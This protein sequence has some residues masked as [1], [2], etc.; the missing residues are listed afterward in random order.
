MNC[1]EVRENAAAALMTGEQNQSSVADHLDTCDNCRREIDELL[2]VVDLLALAPPPA[3]TRQPDDLLLH[4][5]LVQVA[6]ERRRRRMVIGIAVAASVALILAVPAALSVFSDGTRPPATADVATLSAQAADAQT[7]VR[8]TAQLQSSAV[9]SDLVVS[10]RGVEAG[11]RCRLL[12]VNRDGERSVV[13]TWTASY[14]GRATVTTTTTLSMSQVSH[15]E[16]VDAVDAGLL[17]RLD[18]S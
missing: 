10:V 18:F 15:V 16:L 17:L 3:T 8:G 6:G 5:M 4:R 2:S 12:V 13:D 9:G 7:G 14:E 11:T 1:Q